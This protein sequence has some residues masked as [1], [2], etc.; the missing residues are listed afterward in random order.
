M[1]IWA[2][3]VDTDMRWQLVEYFSGKAQLSAAWKE[4]HKEVASFDYEYSEAMNFLSP[5]G[6]SL[7]GC[8]ERVNCD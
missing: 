3:Q 6:F 4:R 2:D 5:P 7:L 8:K 1:L